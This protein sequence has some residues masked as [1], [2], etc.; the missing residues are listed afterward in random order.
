MVRCNLLCS[1]AESL[2]DLPQS[3]RLQRGVLTHRVKASVIPGQP[4]FVGFCLSETHVRGRGWTLASATV[5]HGA[6]LAFCTRGF[7]SV[8][9]HPPCGRD[10][11][12][13]FGGRGV[14]PLKYKTFYGTG[15]LSVNGLAEAYASYVAQ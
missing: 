6:E 12:R 3:V 4:W 11:N 2:G 13:R 7:T 9:A 5:D 10:M 8:S 15:R 1:F 14:C